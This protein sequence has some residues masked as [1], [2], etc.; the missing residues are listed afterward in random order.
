MYKL[1]HEEQFIK[2]DKVQL[3]KTKSI[4]LNMLTNDDV[5]SYI[6]ARKFKHKKQQKL[7]VLEIYFQS[8]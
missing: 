4:E 5:V 8:F 7:G 3:S 6:L 1:V 2:Y